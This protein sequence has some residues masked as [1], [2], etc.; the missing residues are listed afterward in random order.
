MKTRS[1]LQEQAYHAI[2]EMILENELLPDTLY[3]ETKLA[4]QIGVSRTPMREALQCLMQDGYINIIP[5]KGFMIHKLSPKDMRETIQIR[6]ALEGYCVQLI[7]SEQGSKKMTTLLNELDRLITRQ[8]KSITA[9]D[10]PKSFMKY[11][12][13]FHL[14]LI[15]Y[16]DNSEITR[17]FEKSLYHIQLTTTAALS[18]SGRVQGTLDE[19]R[20]I[21]ES[22]KEGDGDGAYRF[23]IA[24]LMFP[25]NMHIFP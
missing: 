8:E 5:S 14:A 12:H 23:M 1:F 25:L 16:A 19:H 15:H 2:K 3:S 18:V 21:Y 13:A 20:Q 4:A 10:F 9:R 6:C 22:L 17:L 11:D 24:H 7:A